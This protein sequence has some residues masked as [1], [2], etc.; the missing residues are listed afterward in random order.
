MTPDP[1]TP[2]LPLARLRQVLE[3]AHEPRELL[4][5]AAALLQEITS[6][7][8]VSLVLP[9][10]GTAAASGL[11]VEFTDAPHCSDIPADRVRDSAA[12][13]V[14]EHRRP[15]LLSARA[16]SDSFGEERRLFEQ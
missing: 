5:E 3:S 4:R 2:S 15:L 8:R 12:A 13:W 14:H 9:A 7:E 16:A 10:R 11:A 6:C 1:P